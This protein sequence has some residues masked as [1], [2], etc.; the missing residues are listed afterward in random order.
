MQN[1]TLSLI[2][3]SV[4][5]VMI[6]S[7][8][9]KSS[10]PPAPTGNVAHALSNT[11]YLRGILDTTWIYQGNDNKE[12]C[13]TN[14]SVCSDF[15]VYGPGASILG[16]K[17]QLT[18]SAH[19]APKDTTILSWVGKTFTASTDTL[20][21]RAFSFSLDY[22]D[23]NGHM[24]STNY[25]PFNA[26]STLTITSVTANGVSQYYLDSITPYKAFLIK[27]TITAKMSHYGDTIA[28]NLTQ[29][30]FAINVIEA[31]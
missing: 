31:K 3:I 5:F 2:A 18:D 20:H 29:G 11:Y 21:S 14:G 7:S 15:L 28:H 23:S 6:A 26:G 9:K 19:P 17:F 10:S 16:V 30:V 27:G 1:K 13:Q 8:C 22:P 24:L 12:E 4:V 25:V